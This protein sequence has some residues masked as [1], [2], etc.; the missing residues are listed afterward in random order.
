MAKKKKIDQQ[1]ITTVVENP[2]INVPVGNLV[3]TNFNDF[4]RYAI[5]HRA[6]PVLYDGCKD[7]YRRLLWAAILMYKAGTLSPAESLVK[8]VARWHPHSVDGIDGTMALFVHSGVFSGEGAFGGVNIADGE[9]DPCAALRYLHI[10][11]SPTY[12][13]LL[14][15]LIKEVPMVESPVGEMEPLYI[16][17]PLPLACCLKS[18][19]MGLSSVKTVIPSFDPWSLY[20]AYVNDDP[21]LLKVNSNINIDYAN[22]NLKEIWEKGKGKI[23]YY[24]N[25]TPQNN[26]V[27]FEGDTW[28]FVPNWNNDKYQKLIE[29]GKIYQL[30][31]TD[32]NGPKAFIGVVPGARGITQNDVINLAKEMYYTSINYQIMITS[33]E[34]AKPIPL[35]KWVELVFKNYIELLVRANNRKIEDCKFAILVQKSI[36]EFSNYILNVNPKATD[37]E[38]TKALGYS[39]EVIKALSG[40]TLA[41]LR[42]NAENDNV[43]KGLEN[44]LNNL[45]AFDP[46][47]TAEEIIKQM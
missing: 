43:M 24:Y 13:K 30:D 19:V 23:T 6:V 37:E 46:I 7:S 31:L 4:S 5:N 36:P 22:S 21:N 38:I 25:V 44:K 14:A 32:I 15:D 12:H 40:K 39:P 16:P 9:M 17:L 42:K 1:L 8:S 45:L 35:K 2:P 47:K 26:G 28:K 18:D 34:S 20:Q 11:L 29:D 27:L 41:T 10:S 33:E 3:A